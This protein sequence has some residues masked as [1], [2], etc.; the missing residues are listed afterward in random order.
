MSVYF[1]ENN[2]ESTKDLFNKSIIYDL[3]TQNPAFSNLVDFNFAEKRLYG[4]VDRLYVPINVSNNVL[5]VKQTSFSETPP[6]QEVSALNFVV[7]AFEAMVQEFVK[8]KTQD[9][10]FGA[11]EFL[12]S[13]RAYK[14]FQS[15]KNLYSQY[16]IGYRDAISEVI[17]EEGIKYTNF[18]T[19]LTKIQPYFENSLKTMPLT[20]PAYVKS[21]ACPATS[22]G[23]VLELADIEYD[24]AEEKYKKFYESPNWEY[25]LNAC[26]K[27]GFMVDK[28]IPWRIV[29]DIASGPML[30]YAAHYFVED[31]DSVL[32]IA[33]EKSHR[34]YFES[35]RTL[36]YNLYTESRMKRFHGHVYVKDNEKQ[37]TYTP[38]YYTMETFKR[39]FND[40]YILKLYCKIRFL[41]EESH[42][43]ENQKKRLTEQTL[44]L[45][46]IDFELA[47]DTFE[48][49]LNKTFDY[50]GSLTYISKVRKLHANEG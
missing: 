34:K 17:E 38:R 14:G 44:E 28:H 5:K 35:F 23:L 4:K 50:S 41:E 43:T 6:G 16:I 13:P 48:I 3:R 22:T 15:P 10:A 19:F 45:A 40:F 9:A 31:T 36:L 37:V 1:K 46:A 12:G 26:A 21:A 11:D 8:K 18:K 25:Y 47:M 27:F 32:S 49:I 30:N 24:K 2:K 7:D 42:F 29:A 20:F 33:Y 39:N